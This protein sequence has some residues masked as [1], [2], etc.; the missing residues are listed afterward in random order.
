CCSWAPAARARGSPSTSGCPT[1]WRAR[2]R[3]RPSSPP[4]PCSPRACTWC[5][6]WLPP[7][8]GGG[9]H[10][11]PWPYWARG[12]AWWRPG[13]PLPIPPLAGFFSKDAILGSALEGRH[14]VLFALGMAT[15]ALT[16]FYMARLL[17]LTFF[18]RFRGGPEAEHHLHESPWVMLAPLVLL[19][20]GSA[21]V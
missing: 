12:P 21:T 11:R 15:A 9:P 4:P 19:A 3:C 20:I 5:R 16:A 10:W 14:A 2:P 7:F 13:P 18:G 17:F 6:G 8:P 1:R